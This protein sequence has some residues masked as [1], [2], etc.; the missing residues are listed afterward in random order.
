M[1]LCRIVS[2]LSILNL[3][4]AGWR[5]DWAEPSWRPRGSSGDSELCERGALP[6]LGASPAVSPDTT[7]LCGKKVRQGT[8]GLD[9]SPEM[10]HTPLT[11]DVDCKLV[12]MASGK[13]PQSHCSRFSES[14]PKHSMTAACR[15][16]GREAGGEE[17]MFRK[18]EWKRWHLGEF[19]IL[20]VCVLLVR[21]ER[22]LGN[23]HWWGQDLGCTQHRLG[24]HRQTATWFTPHVR[25]QRSIQCQLY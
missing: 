12:V 13:P 21:L 11:N 5:G 1:V 25:K 16:P 8:A 3:W 17:L 14:S 7:S 18:G 9:S 19:F 2:T 20:Y 22:H 23:S 15:K 24:I 6:V 4:V 10:A